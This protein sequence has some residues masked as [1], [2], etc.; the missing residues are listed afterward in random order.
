M[1]RL[2]QILDPLVNAI[3]RV[4]FRNFEARAA[5]Q[6]GCCVSIWRALRSFE[7]KVRACVMVRC[8]C[9]CAATPCCT[10]LMYGVVFKDRRDAIERVIS[11]FVPLQHVRYVLVVV[12]A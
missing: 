6:R 2:P 10:L 4:V 12:L 1:E 11:L 9:S 3:H 5:L 8:S 7:P